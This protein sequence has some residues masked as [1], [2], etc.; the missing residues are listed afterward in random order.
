MFSIEWKK[1]EKNENTVANIDVKFDD[2]FINNF[3]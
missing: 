3:N 1:I 2:I